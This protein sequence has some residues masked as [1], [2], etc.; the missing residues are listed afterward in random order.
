MTW[1]KGN[2]FLVE[3]LREKSEKFIRTKSLVY[4]VVNKDS[5]VQVDVLDT[6]S[7][8]ATRYQAKHVIYAGPRFTAAKVIE[9]IETDLELDY[10]PWV[11]ANITLS[12]RPKSQGVQLSW[13]NVSYYSKSLGYIVADH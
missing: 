11:I 7:N 6:A 1:P 5:H 2:G 3:K 12:E 4:A 9:E 8:T 10:A 13:D